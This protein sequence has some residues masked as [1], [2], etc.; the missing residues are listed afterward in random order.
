MRDYLTSVEQAN[1][2]RTPELCQDALIEMLRELFKD[3]KFVGQQGKKRLT[4]YKQD[5][6][7]P[8]DN[9]VDADTHK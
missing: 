9:D 5:L 8:E 6:P 4:F 1:I 7:V 3:R 2:G